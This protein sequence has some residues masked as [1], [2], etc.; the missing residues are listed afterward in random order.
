MAS[1]LPSSRI[2]IWSA[3]SIEDILWAM[4]IFV[5]LFK[6]SFKAFLISLSVFVSTA[7]VLSSKIKILGFFK[8][9]LAIQSLCFW[10]PETFEPPC[11][12]FVSYLSLNDSINS[13]AWAILHAFLISSSLA[14]S[15]PHNKFSLI[16][17]LNKPFFWRTTETLSLS[18]FK[19]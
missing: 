17:P 7:D 11:S 6:S 19:S 5:V 15:L 16:V 2:M 13:S 3:S 1:I 14:N 18:V 8:I 12:I 9:A 4:T 10:P